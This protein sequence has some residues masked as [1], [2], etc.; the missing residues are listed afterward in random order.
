M[1]KMSHGLVSQAGQKFKRM[2]PGVY[3][4]C[5]VEKINKKLFS[6]V[7]YALEYKWQLI[8]SRI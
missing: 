5:V 8:F 1:A 6:L 7:D 2:H 4:L 3:G